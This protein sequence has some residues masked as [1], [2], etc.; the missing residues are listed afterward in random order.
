MSGSPLFKI[1]DTICSKS[2]GNIATIVAIS[3]NS[4]YQTD[5]YVVEWA[6]SPGIKQS[7]SFDDA[8]SSWKLSPQL[9]STKT[10]VQRLMDALNAGTTVWK[11]PTFGDANACDHKWTKYVGFNT[12][13]QFCQKCDEKKALDG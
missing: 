4:I 10:P 7:Y 9:T 3:F 8:H 2:S 5:E 6:H 12:S 11:T 1:Y 13:Y